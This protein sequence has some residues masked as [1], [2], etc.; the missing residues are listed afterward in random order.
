M[1]QLKSGEAYLV[2]I[3]RTAHRPKEGLQFVKSCVSVFMEPDNVNYM[4]LHKRV[5]F[6]DCCHVQGEELQVI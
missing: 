5:L 6:E 3:D 1:F 2:Y 4:I